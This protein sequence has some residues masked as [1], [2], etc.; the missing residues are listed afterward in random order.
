MNLDDLMCKTSS[1]FVVADY[2]NTPKRR[3]CV[4]T[5]SMRLPRGRNMPIVG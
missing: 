1:L 2:S 4:Y 5:F 3:L